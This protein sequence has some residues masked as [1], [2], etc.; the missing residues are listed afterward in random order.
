[1]TSKTKKDY[2]RNIT[3]F[4]RHGYKRVRKKKQE[5]EEH[6][7]MLTHIA[8]NNEDKLSI[9][10]GLSNHRIKDKSRLLKLKEVDDDVD[11]YSKTT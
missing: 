6:I 2:I 3:R 5:Q 7:A 8:Q 1:M 11:Y 10:D 9:D 4:S